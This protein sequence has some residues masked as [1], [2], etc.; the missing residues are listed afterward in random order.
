MLNIK[1]TTEPKIQTFLNIKRTYM[2]FLRKKDEKLK[3]LHRVISPR[4]LTY[5]DHRPNPMLCYIVLYRYLKHRLKVKY[6]KEWTKV[7]QIMYIFQN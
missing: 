1:L 4:K 7:Y 5:M 6:K 2:N 3:Y